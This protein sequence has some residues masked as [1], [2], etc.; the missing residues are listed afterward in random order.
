MDLSEVQRALVP[1]VEVMLQQGRSYLLA[2]EDL[3]VAMV[4]VAMQQ[5]GGNQ[6]VA[7]RK[8]GVTPSAVNQIVNGTA[9]LLRGSKRKAAEKQLAETK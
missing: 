1:G 4:Y 7:A 6:S 3:A 8:L 5:S 2:K 9:Q